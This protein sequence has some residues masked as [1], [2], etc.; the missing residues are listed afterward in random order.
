MVKDQ[1]ADFLE[2]VGEYKYG[3]SDPEN[4]VFKAQKGL[5]RDIVAQ[6]SNLKGEPQ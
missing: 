1:K 2:N 3:F 4:Y 6:I 5:N